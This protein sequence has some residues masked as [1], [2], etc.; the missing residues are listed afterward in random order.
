[1]TPMNSPLGTGAFGPEPQH[2]KQLGALLRDIVGTTPARSV[3]WTSLADRIGTAITMQRATPWWS[4]ANRWERR[5]ISM[6]L[7]AGIAAV[8]A[9]WTS[10]EVLPAQTQLT[11][12]SDAVTA[13]VGGTPAEDAASSF[14]HAVT[15]SADF[16]VGVPE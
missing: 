8:F 2:D 7:A 11:T 1:M 13:V 4:Y 3:N 10:T 12:A 9:L 14:A 5:A 15:G 16:N 6:S